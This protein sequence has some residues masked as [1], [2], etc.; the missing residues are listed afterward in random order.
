MNPQEIQEIKDHI[1]KAVSIGFHESFDFAKECSKMLNKDTTEDIA[2][3]LIIRV[4]KEWDK[5]NERTQVIWNDLV[6]ASGLQPYVDKR[7]LRGSVAIRHEAHLSRSLPNVYLHREQLKLSQFLS[8]GRSLIVSAPTSFGKSLLI[9]EVVA[10]HLYRNIV[11]IQPTLALLDETRKKLNKYSDSYNIVVSTHQHPSKDPNIFLFTGERVVEYD[12]LPR[13][14]FFVIDEFYKLSLERDDERAVTLNQAL[15]RLLKMTNNFYLLGPNIKRI[16]ESFIEKRK[17]LWYR[18]DYSTVAVDIEQVY[19]GKGWKARD[20]RMIDELYRLLPTLDGPTMVYCSSPNKATTLAEGF[21]TSLAKCADPLLI[22]KFKQ[23]NKDI[24]DWIEENIHEKWALG[25]A[26][27][28]GLAFHHGYLPRHLGSAIVDGFNQGHIRYIFCT[29]T[30]IEGVNTTA[31]N[32]VLF[33]QH[34]GMKPIDFFDY[35]NIV[36]RSGRMKIHY[37]GKVFEFH[38]DP[39]QVELD[40]EVPL[41]SQSYAPLELLVQID[42][43]DIEEKVRNKL[44]EFDGLDDALKR[45]IK[46]NS[47]L[48]VEGQLNLIKE[49]EN[50]PNYYYPLL[51]WSTVPS[52]QQ[53]EATIELCWRFLLKQRESKA[54][55]RTPRQLAFMT[56]QYYEGK[57]LRHLIAANLASQ[58][59]MDQEPDEGVRVQKVV[60]IVLGTNRQWFE[61]KL[62]KLLVGI[63]ELQS[64]VFR[65]L[66]KQP[67]NYNYFAASLENSFFKG[68]LSVLMDY[69]VPP[70]AIRKLEHLF[71]GTEDW[72]TIE[73]RLLKL[74][75]ETLNLLPYEARKLKAVLHY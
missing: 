39:T 1:Q 43:E 31:K 74:D 30:L 44:R 53:L 20:K 27:K 41:F 28:C 37:V 22:K 62:P 58:Y 9:E 34:K 48:S 10:S 67:G 32:V 63:S 69:D 35:R 60:Q 16:S 26:L 70:S 56:Q 17:A 66:K 45:I 59:W 15:Y 3:D 19:E 2:R 11:I 4:L 24:I 40:V 52:Y 46:K 75:L 14:D 65:K 71:T 61:Y 38:E 8:E 29:S 47:G 49:V 51:S 68:N 55:V 42:R 54:G 57:S 23:A 25:S 18:S 72:R 73:E 13:I 21:A 50:S 7:S 5:V 12:K 36:G 6:E 64:Y 33:D